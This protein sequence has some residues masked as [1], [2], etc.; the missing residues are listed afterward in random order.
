VSADRGSGRT[1]MS[2]TSP[3]RS[4][5]T[6][7]GQALSD[8][9]TGLRSPFTGALMLNE[10]RSRDTS[11]NSS[12]NSFCATSSPCWKGE[13]M[14]QHLGSTLNILRVPHSL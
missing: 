13:K 1:W 4:L 2:M 6:A 9:R 7:A 5:A 14:F 11:D 12:E 8:T 10:I 3:L